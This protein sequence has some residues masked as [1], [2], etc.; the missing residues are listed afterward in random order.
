MLRKTQCVDHRKLTLSYLVCS[1]SH[2]IILIFYFIKYNEKT[3]Q[4]IFALLWTCLLF[5]PFS[6]YSIMHRCESERGRIKCRRMRINEKKI[7]TGSFSMNR[8]IKS[9][10]E[11]SKNKSKVGKGVVRVACAQNEFV[12]MY[13]NN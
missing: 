5:A 9:L 3:A 8:K 2:Y 1:Y 10:N 12:Y 4:F 6:F 11:K 7:C 13:I